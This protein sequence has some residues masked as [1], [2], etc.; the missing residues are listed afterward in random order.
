MQG[1]LQVLEQRTAAAAAAGTG[2]RWQELE[3]STS[4]RAAQL[5]ACC[6]DVHSAAC[7]G[8]DPQGLLWRCMPQPAGTTSSQLCPDA[9]S[10]LCRACSGLLGRM[11][12][13]GGAV[14]VN[15]GACMY[16]I[17][18]S[19]FSYN[20]GNVGGAL[21]FRGAGTNCTGKSLLVNGAAMQLTGTTI[22]NTVFDQVRGGRGCRLQ[23]A[24]CLL[25]RLMYGMG[26][27]W[28]MSGLVAAW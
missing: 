25:L 10:P 28:P 9:L 6:V 4:G 20:S 8:L 24:A 16:D 22:T 3:R 18:N 7:S 12:Q 11:D 5:L 26:C 2:R 27:G 15:A 19:S 23:R 13:Q 14:V 17:A 21:Y 1:W